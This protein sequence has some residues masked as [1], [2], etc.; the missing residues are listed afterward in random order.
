[1]TLKN[2]A[3]RPFFHPLAS[4]SFDFHCRFLKNQLRFKS[5]YIKIAFPKAI[6]WIFFFVFTFF[7]TIKSPTMTQMLF[8]VLILRHFCLSEAQS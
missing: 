2:D 6:L 4:L 8:L 5:Y 1:M 3:R 7:I